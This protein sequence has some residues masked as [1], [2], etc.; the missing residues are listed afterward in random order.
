MIPIVIKE[1]ER[2]SQ[3]EGL[4]DVEI[5]DK[6][7]IHRVTI[8]N[9]RKKYNIPAANTG[10]RYDKKVICTKCNK[11]FIIRRRERKP[12]KPICSLCKLENSEKNKTEYVYAE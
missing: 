5:A 3:E 10:N 12:R 6:L 4:Y 1:I 9:V 2:L 7:G 8:S 11:E